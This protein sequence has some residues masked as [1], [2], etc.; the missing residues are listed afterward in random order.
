MKCQPIYT[1]ISS[2][3]SLL[4][5]ASLALLSGCNT[6]IFHP[7]KQH[8]PIPEELGIVKQD[9]YFTT[10]DGLRLH[11][12]FLPAKQ[13]AK[14]TV[15]FLHGNAQNVSTHIANIWWMPEQQLNVFLFDYRGFGK[16]EG[17]PTLEGLQLDTASA[18]DTLFKRTDINK[19]KVVVYGQSLGAAIAITHLAH[20]E[21]RS[22]LQAII[23]EGGFTSF[24]DVAQ[25]AL[26]KWWVTWAFQ[27]PLSLTISDDNRPIDNIQYLS[28]TPVLIVHG[29]DDQIIEVHHAHELFNAAKDPKN[30]WFVTRSGHNSATLSH[31][32]RKQLIDYIYQAVD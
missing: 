15:L 6:L 3:R 32:Y 7:E 29:K 23:L 26:D 8:Y 12:W 19:E 1:G 20:S 16:S 18:L 2:L 24:R 25:E 27:W 14:G 31:D 10:A 28:P 11:G 4:I 17:E 21:Y 5:V 22:R 30:L 13:P 9:V